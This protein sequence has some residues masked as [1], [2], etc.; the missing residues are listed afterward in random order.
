[1]SF[2][3]LQCEPECQ[4]RRA[5]KIQRC[6]FKATVAIHLLQLQ[7]VTQDEAL[8]V[9]DWLLPGEHLADFHEGFV[10]GLWDNEVDINGHWEANSGKHQV[11][12]GASRHLRDGEE[13]ESSGPSSDSKKHN[14]WKW[15]NQDSNVS[16]SLRWS[17]IY[18]DIN[19]S[20]QSICIFLPSVLT[21]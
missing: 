13:E 15:L 5:V 20:R 3:E 9:Q 11:A 18:P 17:D 8:A 1:M 12:E 7:L 16:T 10:F 14:Q 4:L 21:K 19:T 6:L 2:N